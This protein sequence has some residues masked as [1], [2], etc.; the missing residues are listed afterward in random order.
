MNWIEF[1][2]AWDAQAAVFGTWRI[3]RRADVAT[4]RAFRNW[5][6]GG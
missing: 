6:K 5:A 4:I 1:Y 3:Y 2:L